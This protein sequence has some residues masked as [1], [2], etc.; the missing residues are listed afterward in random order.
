VSSFSSHSH[1]V[2]M[3]FVGVSSFVGMPAPTPPPVV[4]ACVLGCTF[5]Q[6]GRPMCWLTCWDRLEL[7]WDCSSSTMKVEL[8]LARLCGS[9]R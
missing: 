9:Q 7:G 8:E 2:T 3:G 4:A 1:L 6:M 5:W